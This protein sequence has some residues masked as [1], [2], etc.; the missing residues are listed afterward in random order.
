MPLKK[1]STLPLTRI[2]GS[3]PGSRG[4]KT[5]SRTPNRTPCSKSYL[6]SR[7]TV[8]GYKTFCTQSYSSGV[9]I[10][11]F[12]SKLHSLLR[13]ILKAVSVQNIISNEIYG[14]TL[15][16]HFC[17][18]QKSKLIRLYFFVENRGDVIYL[19]IQCINYINSTRICRVETTN[20][21]F[22]I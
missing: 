19:H 6:F 15:I 13:T 14:Q 1:Y 17:Q 5:F 8:E 4:H 10:S 11:N 2:P 21:C 12:S 9:Q 22:Y 16:S 7:G 18:Y 20:K 3:A